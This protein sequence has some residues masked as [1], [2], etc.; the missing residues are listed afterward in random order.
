MT[1]LSITEARKKIFHLTD[2]IKKRSTYVTLTENGK[3]TVV[4]MSADEFDSWQETLEIMD[5]A[6]LMRSLSRSLKEVQ[7]GDII[8]LSAVLANT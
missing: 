8:P 7:K 6:P 1:T 3:P 5:N 4:M 2:D